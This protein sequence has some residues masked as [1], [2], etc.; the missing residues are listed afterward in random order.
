MNLAEA[1]NAAAPEI[2]RPRRDR[3]F[4]LDPALIAKEQLEAGETMVMV[5]NRGNGNLF[6]FPPAVWQVLQ[7]FDGETSCE[8]IASAI[9]PTFPIPVADLKQYVDVLAEA[10]F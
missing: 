10:G 7:L 9:A 4:R 6:R 1:L 2:V 8:D 3:F 5:F